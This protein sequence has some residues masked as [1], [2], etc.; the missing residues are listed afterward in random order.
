[1]IHYIIKFIS[2]KYCLKENGA[3]ATS[4][5]NNLLKMFS[6]A[7]SAVFDYR[8]SCGP[9]LNSL[10]NILFNNLGC[11]LMKYRLNNKLHQ[12][13]EKL[14][15]PCFLIVLAI[16]FLTS[17]AYD[18][19][20]PQ[21][22]VQAMAL[23][24]SITLASFISSFRSISSI[25]LRPFSG[26]AA[27]TFN[28]KHIMLLS[29]ALV[30]LSFL[31]FSLSF[32]VAVYATSCIIVGFAFSFMSVA[33]SAFGVCYMPKSRLGEGISLISFSLILSEMVSPALGLWLSARYGF[34]AC[35]WAAVGLETL[36][37]FLL[38]IIP[39]EHRP[40]EKKETDDKRKLRLKDLVAFPLLP[41]SLMSG[42]FSMGGTMTSTYLVLV[43]ISRGLG[44]MG[45]FFTAVS[46]TAILTR[47]FI[48]K[49]YD[50]KG[51]K[52]I[53]IPSYICGALSLYL[54]GRSTSMAFIIAAGIAKA[55]GQGGG[56]PCVQAEAIRAA[57][58]HRAG[59]AGSTV[60]I[61]QDFFNM[62]TPILCGLALGR[63]ADLSAGYTFIFNAG[64]VLMLMGILFYLFY[65]KRLPSVSQQE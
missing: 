9:S 5:L 64:A 30:W 3:A 49:L 17:M 62:M 23:G 13:N 18:F 8:R 12:E 20:T 56:Q 53:L 34:Y 57:G 39:Y 26:L 14:L 59:I 65:E 22:S 19:I 44:N 61:G 41:F 54:V 24:A 50:K 1:M 55:I 46:V 47:P 58:T 4:L 28:R 60:H 33:R 35:S 27:D 10:M 38:L 43:G 32:H 31:G 29:I 16:V 25:L 37:V 48:G 40:K 63:F 42:L 51:L 15:N 7:L 36:C 52:P 11:V 6:I 21:L 45:I 2:C